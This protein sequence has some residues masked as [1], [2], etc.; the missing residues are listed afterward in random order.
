VVDRPGDFARCDVNTAPF[1]QH[2]RQIVVGHWVVVAERNRLHIRR[3]GTGEIRLVITRV[4]ERHPRQ[5]L[6]R[7]MLNRSRCC[8]FSVGRLPDGVEAFTRRDPRR[9]NGSGWELI[10]RQG[11]HGPV[12]AGAPAIQKR[13][14]PQAHARLSARTQQ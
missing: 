13:A 12:V 10:R 6:I 9:H 4:A 7:P 3:F 1:Q 2:L 5:H 14:R 8:G 11:D